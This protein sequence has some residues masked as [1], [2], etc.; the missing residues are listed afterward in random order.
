MKCCCKIGKTNSTLY[1]ELKN[2]RHG[3]N[4]FDKLGT[5]K[6]G[7]L[8]KNIVSNFGFFM[9]IYRPTKNESEKGQNDS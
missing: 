9:H 3:G 1:S 4:Y 5:G 2:R 8:W 7:S 6:N